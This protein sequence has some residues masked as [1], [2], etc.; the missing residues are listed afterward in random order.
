MH[1]NAIAYSSPSLSASPMTP[2][3]GVSASPSFTYQAMPMQQY[4]MQAVGVQPVVFTAAA[5]TPT[6]TPVREKPRE[7]EK[8]Y[9]D[10]EVVKEVPVEVVK[11]VPVTTVVERYVCACGLRGSA[12][13]A[14]GPTFVA[15]RGSPHREIGCDNACTLQ[16]CGSRER[17][18][19]YPGRGGACGEGECAFSVARVRTVKLRAQGAHAISGGGEP[20]PAAAGRDSI[21]E[22]GTSARAVLFCLRRWSPWKRWW[23][24]LLIA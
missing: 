18:N 13:R 16:V 12:D 3:S 23:R 10:R 2:V 7:T 14:D 6:P 15:A 19:R 4:S 21:I 20:Q 24:C 1:M 8:V 5:P 11:E 9:V 17:T 22:C